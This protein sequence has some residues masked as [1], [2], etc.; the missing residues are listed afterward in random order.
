MEKPKVTSLH[1][2]GLLSEV[3]TM[4][5]IASKQKLHQLSHKLHRCQSISVAYGNLL[6]LVGLKAFIF[7]CLIRV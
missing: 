4:V 3:S 5:I 6:S 7:I 2:A 1:L